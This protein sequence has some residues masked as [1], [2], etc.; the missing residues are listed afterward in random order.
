MRSI[1]VGL[2]SGAILQ[3]S[4]VFSTLQ[5]TSESDNAKPLGEDALK[6]CEG[7]TRG[8]WHE[9]QIMKIWK[10]VQEHEN[11]FV[12][13]LAALACVPTVIYESTLADVHAKPYES[14]LAHVLAVHTSLHSSSCE[15][16]DSAL[17]N[18]FVE[19][20]VFALAN[21]CAEPYLSVLV[22]LPTVPDVFSLANVSA[23]PCEAALSHL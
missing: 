16:Y 17:V 21:L 2:S 8:P 20:D 15:P 14:V 23:E 4:P 19:P 7:V 18:V 1:L 3:R 6:R 9:D 11:A 22:N 12:N 10:T 13:V 5:T